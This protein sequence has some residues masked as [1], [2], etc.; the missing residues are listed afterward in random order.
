MKKFVAA[1][2]AATTMAVAAPVSAQDSLKYASLSP[3]RAAVISKGV[4]PFLDAIEADANGSLEIQRFPG[5]QLV[6]SP[7]AIFPSLIEGVYDIAYFGISDI[8]NQ[9]PY[10]SVYGL[11]GL[12]ETPQESA[13]VMWRMIEN[14]AFKYPDEVVP[15]AV[16]S[17]GNAGLYLRDEVSS[18]SAISG[19][20]VASSGGALDLISALG[21]SPVQM[22]I[23]EVAPSITSKV[24][25]GS[26]AGWEA[27]RTFQIG[28]TVKTFVDAPLGVNVFVLSMSRTAYDGLS[29]EA[30]AAVDANRGS[31][32]S[33][34][35]AETYANGVKRAQKAAKEA[36]NFIEVSEDE[37]ADAFAQ[38]HDAWLEENGEEGK[39]IYETLLS[40]ID[41]VR[42][43]S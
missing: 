32:V 9:F 3:E 16:F 31:A 36:G 30:R 43:G 13:E 2:V 8:G 10:G 40:V 29:D 23:T 12:F 11:P 19:Q 7:R 27:L 34:S 20:K 21:G 39:A 38:I 6:K 33:V 35:I 41:E 28:P 42:A 4:Y 17:N 26:I 24:I 22:G 25:D 18:L 14:G 1:A 37:V 5:R 15:L